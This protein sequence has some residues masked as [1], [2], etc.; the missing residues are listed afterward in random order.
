[1]PSR[2]KRASDRGCTRPVG[3]LPALIARR[4]FGA[5]ELKV[6]SAR[7]DRQ[8]LPVHRNKTFIG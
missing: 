1:M 7:T 3:L 8:E 4:P 2:F 6:A 5:S